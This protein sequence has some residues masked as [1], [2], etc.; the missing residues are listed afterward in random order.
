[1]GLPC[2]AFSALED[3]MKKAYVFLAAAMVVC[4]CA[5]AFAQ[6][7]D[8]KINLPFQFKIG[9]NQFEAGSYSFTQ[10]TRNDR[11]LVQGKKGRNL[12][13]TSPLVPEN[14]SDKAHTTLVFH[15]NGDKYFLNQLWTKHIGFQ[16]PLSAE[17]KELIAGGKEM[18]EVK[19]NVKMQ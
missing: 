5:P 7:N 19:V 16:M 10:E 4:F 15:K 13:S 6:F 12:I 14:P 11:M 8:L 18:S 9:D 17:E 3:D 1:V 2:P